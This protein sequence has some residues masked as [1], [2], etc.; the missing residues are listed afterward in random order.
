M[1]SYWYNMNRSKLILIKLMWC[2]LAIKPNSRHWMS[3]A[4]FSYHDTPLEL[5]ENTKYLGMFINSDISW[6]FYLRPLWQTTYCHIS[7]SRRLCHIFPINLLLQ[8]YKDY[9]HSRLDY[10]NTLYGSSTQKNTDLVQRVQNHAARMKIG[11]FDYINSRGI[12]L[13]ICIQSAK[14]GII[15]FGC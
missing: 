1:V 8:V 4:F 2:L 9:I 12:D 11:N 15:F 3:M 5:V 13:W 10:G 6:E 14:G 7:S